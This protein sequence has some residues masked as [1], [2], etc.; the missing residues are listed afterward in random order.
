MIAAG[1]VVIMEMSE[2]EGTG[3]WL[4]LLRLTCNKL[5]NV[6]YCTLQPRE[7]G[8]IKERNDVSLLVYKA[9]ALVTSAR[10]KRPTDER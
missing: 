9:G 2:L 5:K 3:A 8:R 7:F 6:L 4:P 10:K 1:L